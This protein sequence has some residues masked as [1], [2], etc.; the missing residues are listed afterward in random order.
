MFGG[1]FEDDRYFN[2]GEKMRSEN[3]IRK[4]L[5]ECEH[6][7]NEDPWYRGYVTALKWTLNGDE[8]LTQKR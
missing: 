4:E 1:R 6:R 7:V 2:E 5:A 8:V 3:E